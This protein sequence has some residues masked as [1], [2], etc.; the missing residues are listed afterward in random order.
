MTNKIFNEALIAKYDKAGPRYTSY[1][2]AVQFTEEFGEKEYIEA[3]KASNAR[4]NPLSLYFHVP[5]CA[6]ICFYCGCNKIITNNRKRSQPYLDRLYKEIEM[7]GALF[8][9]KAP[10]KQ[11][12]WGGGTPTFLS[13][14]EM[15]SLMDKTREEF[16]ILP[17]DEAEISIEVDP[18]EANADTVRFLRS[19]GF[20]RLSMGVQDFDDKVQVAVNRI[21]PKEITIE[22]LTAARESGFSSISLDLIYGLPFQTVD[23]FARTLDE[24]ITLS[25][26]RLSIFNYAH[27]PHIFKT[28]K[29][30]NPEDMPSPQEKLLILKQMIERL[31]EAGYVYIGMDH[32]AKPTDQ[33]A[34]AQK[35]GLL[36]RNFQGYSTHSDCDLV[37]MGIS[38]IS[39]IG[40]IYAQNA[41]IMPQYEEMID[42]G[43]LPIMR[44]VKLTQDDLIRRHVITEIMCNLKLDLDQVSKDLGID[45]REYFKNDLPE[46]NAMQDD[47]LI[48]IENDKYFVQDSGRLLIRNIG[49]VFDAY[50]RK[51]DNR[52]SRVI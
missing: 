46:L 47:G 27:M 14:D 15:Q 6:T 23:S 38:S 9:N 4:K 28:Q 32:F 13:H 50:L 48:I 52:F 7:Q 20:N 3:A 16:N 22:T 29:Q 12:H 37:G 34:I 31:T 8:D 51:N 1:P 49:M 41:K 44:G 11:L 17:N 18:R 33:L 35:E 43:K 25:P 26:D 40:D 19:L 36:Y 30:M 10:V 39:Q 21:Q 24:V 2:T 5:F 45:A 42:N